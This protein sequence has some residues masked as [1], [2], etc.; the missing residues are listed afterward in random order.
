MCDPDLLVHPIAPIAWTCE[1]VVDLLQG[2][3]Q[4]INAEEGSVQNVAD[5]RIANAVNGYLNVAGTVEP[6]KHE[7]NSSEV[8]RVDVGFTSFS[9]KIGILP[10][11]RIPLTW[12]KTPKVTFLSH[13][14]SPN[15]D[16]TSSISSS[17]FTLNRYSV[18]LE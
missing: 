16:I 17:C 10:Q 11:L 6:I 15:F 13:I 5:F 4:V 12:P 18:H 1:K 7:G 2:I 8:I 14:I 9:L 3:T